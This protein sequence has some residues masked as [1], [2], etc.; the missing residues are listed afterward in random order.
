M[1]SLKYRICTTSNRLRHLVLVYINEM[2]GWIVFADTT[3]SGG[4]LK[5]RLTY[6]LN[7]GFYLTG[8]LRRV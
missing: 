1:P 4:Q 7:Q 5:R 2:N 6:W 3:R 8:W